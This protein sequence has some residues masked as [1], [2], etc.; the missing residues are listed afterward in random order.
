MTE[1]EEKIFFCGSIA[2]AASFLGIRMDR[3]MT[4][5]GEFLFKFFDPMAK[6]FIKGASSP[7][8]QKAFYNACETL[9]KYLDVKAV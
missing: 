7:D 4:E 1:H 9:V 6:T 5:S 3:S 8:R 2:K